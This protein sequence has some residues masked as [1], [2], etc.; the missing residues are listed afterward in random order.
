MEAT[1]PAGGNQQLTTG[2][3]QPQVAINYF[4]Q[5]PAE[6]TVENLLDASSAGITQSDPHS[7]GGTDYSTAGGDLMEVVTEAGQRQPVLYP[8]GLA[9]PTAATDAEIL[10]HE[11]HAYPEDSTGIRSVEVNAAPGLYQPVPRLVGL[12]GP[13]IAAGEEILHQ[14]NSHAEWDWPGTNPGL[15]QTQLPPYSA[16]EPSSAFTA[17]GTEEEIVQSGRALLGF[18]MQEVNAALTQPDQYSYSIGDST[19]PSTPTPTPTDMGISSPDLDVTN[20]AG[21]PQ[22]GGG[23]L[24]EAPERGSCKRKCLS[25]SS[26][27]EADLVRSDPWAFY[28][29]LARMHR[30]DECSTDIKPPDG[31]T[32][33]EI[34][35]FL[36]REKSNLLGKW[37]NRSIAEQDQTAPVAQRRYVTNMRMMPDQKTHHGGN[38]YWQEKADYQ[39]VRTIEGSIWRFYDVIG[40]KRT[41]RFHTSNGKE[42]NWFM[43]EYIP[44]SNWGIDLYLQVSKDRSFTYW[45]QPLLCFTLSITPLV[46]FTLLILPLN[47]LVV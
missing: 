44:T 42:T 34:I 24:T 33:C 14:Q 39:V 26:T 35:Q 1:Y 18:S 46:R 9:G 7:T 28:D 31:S 16:G 20:Q 19:C 5:V 29:T 43:H 40:I 8:L 36:N 22:S 4:Q 15:S 37:I 45:D 25:S 6:Y 17:T 32:P 2:S 27:E 41:F 11:Q 23:A 13:T 38:G 10:R 21:L 12:V 3:P 47:L 30:R